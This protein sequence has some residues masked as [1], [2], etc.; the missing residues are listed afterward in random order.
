MEQTG[1]IARA[2]SII[3]GQEPTAQKSFKINRGPP[4]IYRTTSTP[5]A[6]AEKG[7]MERLSQPLTSQRS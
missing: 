1:R 3:S 6:G 4:M 2:P 7:L 5:I